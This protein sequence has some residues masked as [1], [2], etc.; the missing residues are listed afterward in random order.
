M[1]LAPTIQEAINEFRFGIFNATF[2]FL[3]V[4]KI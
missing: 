3:I 4:I 2:N 1:I